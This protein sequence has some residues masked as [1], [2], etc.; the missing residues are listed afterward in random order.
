MIFAMIVVGVGFLLPL[1]IPAAPGQLIEGTPQGHRLCNT[2]RCFPTLAE[3]IENY[4]LGVVPQLECQLRYPRPF[5]VMASARERRDSSSGT[6]PCVS[7]P[8]PP[9]RHH[10]PGPARP[11]GAETCLVEHGGGGY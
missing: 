1:L 11:T 2:A 5:H 4:T 9:N 7:P 10:L 3:A 6:A 8:P